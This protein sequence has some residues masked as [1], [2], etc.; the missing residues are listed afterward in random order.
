MYFIPFILISVFIILEMLGKDKKHLLFKI[1]FLFLTVAICLRYGQGTDYFGY[2]AL[3]FWP[4][5]GEGGYMLLQS[6]VSRL[7]LPFELMIAVIALFQML[8][9]YRVIMRHSPYKLFSLLLLYP[10][11]YLTYFF[12]AIRQGIVIAFFL[13]FM[14][15]WILKDKWVK[16]L[17]A[18]IILATFHSSALVLIPLVLIKKIDEKILWVGLGLAVFAGAF[19]LFAPA[20]CFSFIK[21]GAVQYHIQR[22]EL[23]PMGLAERTVMF[24]L[25]TFFYRRLHKGVNYISSEQLSVLYRIYFVG[26]I[27]AVVFFPW[28]LL[29][30]RMGAMM[31][32]LEIILIPIFAYESEKLRKYIV[33]VMMGYVL[34]MTTKNINSYIHQNNYEGYNVLTYP[35][36]SIWDQEEAHKVDPK[37]WKEIE[38]YKRKSMMK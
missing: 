8:C 5:H 4:D 13:G 35:Y 12:S 14:L 33:T 10:T 11:I 1:A 26:Y 27:I 24:V 32:A 23:S 34:L 16:Y 30:S 17:V 9:I 20:E 21:I 6:L 28:Q 22:I 15:E 18:C 38:K 3:F 29:S 7:G 36:Y 2:M 31:K 37:T 25:I 19:I